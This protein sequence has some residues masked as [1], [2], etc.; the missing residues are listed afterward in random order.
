MNKAK[1]LYAQ[2]QQKKKEEEKQKRLDNIHFNEENY[3]TNNRTQLLGKITSEKDKQDWLDKRLLFQNKLA[4][5]H[6]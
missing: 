3:G 5:Y 4:D 6:P 2:S 1:E